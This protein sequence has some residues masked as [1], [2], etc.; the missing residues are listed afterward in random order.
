MAETLNRHFLKEEIEIAQ[1]H[2]KRCSTSLVI[3][4]MQIK[5]TVYDFTPVRMA[6][7][8]KFANSK[9]QRRCGEKGTPLHCWWQ[10]KLVQTLWTK[11][12]R[13]LKKIKIEL[14]Y[15]PAIPFLGMY[16]GKNYTLKRYIHSSVHW[17][18]TYN[19]QNVE[20]T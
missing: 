12:W 18:T 5:T 8:K 13:F 9:C 2:L 20:A 10:C 3:R 15:D 14:P 6:I 7:I 11:A 19:S 17:N 1:K 16:L 4:E